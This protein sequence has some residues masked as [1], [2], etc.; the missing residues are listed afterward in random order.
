MMHAKFQNYRT[1]GSGVEDFLR[2]FTIYGQG[3]HHGYVTKNIY[4]LMYPL[5]KEALHKIWL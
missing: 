2:F 4:I 3:G 1:L 5:P